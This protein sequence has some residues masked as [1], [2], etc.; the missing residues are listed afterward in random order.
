[1]RRSGD[2]RRV[3]QAAASIAVTVALLAWVVTRLDRHA[4]ASELG[5]VRP[6]W[7]L[8]AAALGPLQVALAAERWRVACR[9][10]GQPLARRRAVTEVALS[11]L[12]NQLLPGGIAGDAIRA[13]RAHGGPAAAAPDTAPSPVGLAASV[14]A[15]LADRMVG[16]MVHMAVVAAGLAGWLS[17]HD[18]PL[19]PGAVPVALIVALGLAGLVLA[20]RA[21]PGVGGL[22]ADLRRILGHPPTAARAVLLSALSTGSFLLGFALCAQALGSSLGAAAFTA[23]P[24]VLLSMAVPIGFAGWGLREATAAAVLPRLGWSL[25]A[26]VALSACYGLSVLIGALPGAVVPMLPG[27]R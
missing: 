14:R 10:L 25:E 19:P 17:L 22:G 18:A 26:A 15:V 5:A 6:A 1:M 24:L 20:P 2:D 21:L 7:L 3:V 13:W 11:N 8:L 9:R 12:L 23:V 4:L 16:L 27:E